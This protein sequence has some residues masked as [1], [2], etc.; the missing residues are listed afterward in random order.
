MI[1]I[2]CHILPGIDDGPKTVDES[3][4]MLRLAADDGVRTI[5]ATPHFG[6]SFGEPNPEVI[7]SLA[8]QL[9]ERGSAQAIPVR[10]LP[11]CEA[12]VER[13]LPEMVKRGEVLTLGDLGQY[14]LIELPGPPLPLYALEVHFELRLAGFVPIELGDLREGILPGT[15]AEFYQRVFELSHIEVLGIGA[16]LGCLAGVVPI[17]A[18]A[19]RIVG[20]ASA[21]KFVEEFVEQGGLVQVNAGAVGGLEGWR[22]KRRAR[23][24]FSRDLAHV[25]AS[26]GHSTGR[27][28]PVLTPC[29]RGFPR[30]ERST[31]LDRYCSLNLAEPTGP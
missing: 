14:V 20:A 9:N 16:N 1:D 28:R 11:G 13:D 4:A 19:E 7:R 5:V 3:L 27:R 6:G 30:R 10:V 8:I 31:V 18:H 22:G 12:R 26:D 23:R 29:L 24:L 21:W 25:I 2:H 15:L 17:L